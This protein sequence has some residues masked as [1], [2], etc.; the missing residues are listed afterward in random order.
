MEAAC[1][2]YSKQL[3][4]VLMNKGTSV[5]YRLNDIVDK[6]LGFVHFL[7]GIGH[8]QTVQVLVLV[9]GVSG[10]RFA[11]TLLDRAFAANGNL[12]L[13]LGLHLLERVTTRTN[14]QADC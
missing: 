9:A 4:D 11:F 7:F 8:D 12:G 5:T 10:I 14:E 3:V 2:T 13:R 1:H 6:L